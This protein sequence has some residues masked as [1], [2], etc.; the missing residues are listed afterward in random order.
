[1][2]FFSETLQHTKAKRSSPVNRCV[3][4]IFVVVT[5]I[6]LTGIALAAAALMKS[7]ISYTSSSSSR[8]WTIMLRVCHNLT[9]NSSV[10]S[11][12][13]GLATTTGRL[14]GPKHLSQGR[15]D[16]LLHRES[17][18]GIATFSITS[19]TLY[20]MNCAAAAVYYL[21]KVEASR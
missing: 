5:L 17:N 7:V 2:K 13:S 16:E 6:A 18:Q 19:P 14:L 1:M 3:P 15:S 10:C 21:F 12:L 4:I 8:V 11:V 9:Q 20:Q